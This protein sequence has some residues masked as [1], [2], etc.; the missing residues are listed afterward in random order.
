MEALM[1]GID[2]S[3]PWFDPAVRL[4]SSRTPD[5]FC[6]DHDLSN[7]DRQYTNVALICG[8]GT[9][10]DE[11]R[12]CSLE[13]LDDDTILAVEVADLDVHWME[14]GD[15]HIDRLPASLMNGLDGQGVLVLFA[16][17]TVQYVPNSVPLDDLRKL[18]TIEGAKQHDRKTLLPQ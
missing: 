18:M 5:Y 17:S 4:L 10:F 2:H 7:R 11:S 1:L 16:D 14:P 6:F 15:L 12:T 3:K 8:P 13:D 9:P